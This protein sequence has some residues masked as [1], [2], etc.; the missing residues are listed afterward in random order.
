MLTLKVRLLRSP[1]EGPRVEVT[2]G[3][4]AEVTKPLGLVDDEDLL[5]FRGSASSGPS[6]PD[7][8]ARKLSQKQERELAAAVGGRT[9]PG[10]GALP[11]A[12]GDFRV[13]GVVRGEAK[14]TKAASYRL[15]LADLRKIRSECAGREKMSFLVRFLD[16]DGRTKDEFALISREDWEEWVEFKKGQRG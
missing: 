6:A 16:T 7:K 13:N 11:G 2:H 5:V 12:K 15:E 1:S 8:K 10:S 4:E 9:Q 14:C 3:L